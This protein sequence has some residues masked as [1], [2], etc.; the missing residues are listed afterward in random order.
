MRM[1]VRIQVALLLAFLS[2]PA[3]ARCGAPVH[4]PL[5]SSKLQGEREFRLETDGS[6]R[7][8]NTGT[9]ASLLRGDLDAGGT[10][11]R[12]RR[13]GEAKPFFKLT[14]EGVPGGLRGFAA[15][16]DDDGDG[17]LDE[18]PLDGLDNDQDGLVDED[19]AA[20]GD[21]MGAMRLQRAGLQFRQEIYRWAY[22]HLQ[23]AVF[24][25]IV[26]EPG[27][28]G[29]ARLRLEAAGPWVEADVRATRHT[30]A[31]KAEHRSGSALVT[32]SAAG[33]GRGEDGAGEACA[34]GSETW[35]GVMILDEVDAGGP[36]GPRMFTE[37]GVLEIDLTD[38][39]LSLVLVTGDSWVQLAGLLAE[40][41]R[42][43]EGVADPVSGR[44]ARWIVPALCS[45]CRLAEPPAFA[46]ETTPDGGLVLRTQLVSGQSRLLDPD[47]FRIMDLPLGHPSRLVWRGAEG[48]EQTVVWDCGDFGA[49]VR[50]GE[51]V[52]APWM[53]LPALQSHEDSG[54][55]ELWFDDL[56]P[57]LFDTLDTAAQ[58]DGPVALAGR[59]GDGRTLRAETTLSHAQDPGPVATTD[60]AG[61]MVD[62]SRRRD[63]PFADR[64][65]LTLSPELLNGWPN[66]FRDRIQIRFKVPASVGEAFVWDDDKDRPEESVLQ[67]P[68]PWEGGQPEASVKIYSVTGQELMTL[69][70]GQHS[71]GEFTVQ[72]DGSD[73]HGR[74]VASGTYFCKLQL[75]D[76]SATR[77]IVYLR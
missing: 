44:R 33:T 22:P 41:Q 8:F 65:R 5:L 77:L 1:I 24:L 46:A 74:P 66:P 13:S 9:E 23:P 61:A 36:P 59:Y 25:C 49:L 3:P 30:L 57:D 11:G 12:A 60:L 16:A 19:F 38:R 39:P 53:L 34:A 54:R 31:G 17:R 64:S 21:T 73:S 69:Y 20:I 26:P 6:F 14:S 15:G 18:D 52:S 45:R 43:H 27:A 50:G 67:T 62:L 63:D 28:D 4:S 56:D 29:I 47:L 35:L 58:A 76:W 42:V 75:D 71:P 48:P 10:T 68:V 32:A 55:L 51:P 7:I 72:W 70:T 40:A 2:V 37:D